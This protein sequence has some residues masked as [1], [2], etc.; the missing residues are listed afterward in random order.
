MD[1]DFTV[2]GPHAGSMSRPSEPEEAMQCRVRMAL[3]GRAFKRTVE[4]RKLLAGCLREESLLT[5]MHT[6]CEHG[7][8]GAC[9]ILM[10]TEPVRSWLILAVRSQARV[11]D[12][13]VEAR[14]APGAKR[15]RSAQETGATDG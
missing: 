4:V 13:R 15:I 5:G 2:G 6:G 3:N 10:N 1:G 9:T 11:V 12:N 7:I 8:C 14:A